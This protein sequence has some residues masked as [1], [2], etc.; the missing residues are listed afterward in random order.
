[1]IRILLISF[2]LVTSTS[3]LFAAKYDTS[4]DFDLDQIISDPSI[5]TRC[6]DILTKRHQKI[7][8]KQRLKELIKRSQKGLKNAEKGKRSTAKSRLELTM[9]KIKQEHR[10]ISLKIKILEE[11]LVRKGCPGVLL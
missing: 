1:M 6:K 11:R 3:D 10:L 2:L 8:I 4:G 7:T 5:T 9:V